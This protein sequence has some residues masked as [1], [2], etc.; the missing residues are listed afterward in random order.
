MHESNLGTYDINDNSVHIKN[1]SN[2]PRTIYRIGDTHNKG[3]THVQQHSIDT[4]YIRI[5]SHYVR[6][7][8][9][10]VSTPICEHSPISL[11]LQLPVPQVPLLRY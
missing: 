2:K 8:K 10:Y 7:G 5:S 11:R 9:R 3:N 6:I 1:K 4:H